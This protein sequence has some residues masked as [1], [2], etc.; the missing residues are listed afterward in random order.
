MIL[1]FICDLLM[2]KFTLVLRRNDVKAAG[3]L[4]ALEK[5]LW[6]KKAECLSVIQ[7]RI[8]PSGSSY[9]TAN[10]PTRRCYRLCEPHFLQEVF[11]SH[12]KRSLFWVVIVGLP[13]CFQGPAQNESRTSP[14]SSPRPCDHMALRGLIWTSIIV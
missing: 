8:D 11:M 6:S 3:I 14:P 2:Q 4:L 12:V 5:F 13:A 1:L 9:Y 7:L 10:C